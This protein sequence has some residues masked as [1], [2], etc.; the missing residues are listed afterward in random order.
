MLIF[1]IVFCGGG[2]TGAW[3]NGRRCKNYISDSLRDSIGS[4]EICGTAP[5]DCP[6]CH[7]QKMQKMAH[8]VLKTSTEREYMDI[9]H[10]LSMT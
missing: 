4:A 8:S 1:S 2:Y 5:S 9:T 10:N 7:R 6:G 3:Q